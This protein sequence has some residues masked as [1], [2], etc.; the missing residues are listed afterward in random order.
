MLRLGWS[1]RTLLAAAGYVAL[2]YLWLF[3]A[4]S[5]VVPEGQRAF[6][7]GACLLAALVVYCASVA[8]PALQREGGWAKQAAWGAGAA[9]LIGVILIVV[10][11][12][13]LWRD[14]FFH[15]AGLQERA[16]SL[17]LLAAGVAAIA[18]LGAPLIGMIVRSVLRP[19]AT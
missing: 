9:V 8:G 19:A 2:N 17:L 7:K 10:S 6:W 4:N 13:L 1:F 11:G 16:P 5:P 15:D 3:A 12:A 18:A 14:Q